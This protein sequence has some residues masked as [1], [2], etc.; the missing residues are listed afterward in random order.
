MTIANPIYDI[1]FKY[2]MEDL[3]IAKGLLSTILNTEIV[4][5]AVQPQEAV[6]ETNH[7]DIAIRIFRIDFAAIIKE[8]DGATRKILIELQ[9]T[10]RSTN[11]GRFRRYLAENY[12]K[13]DTII[14][15]GIETKESLEIVTIYFLGFNLDTVDAPVLYVKNDFIDVINGELVK[16]AAKEDFVRLLTHE[17]YMIQLKKLPPTT[18]TRLER[19]LK[20]FNQVYKLKDDHKL[21]IVDDDNDPLV[22]KMCTRL[23][24]A[25]AD[26]QMRK[27][28][29]IED[30]IDQ[31]FQ[32]IDNKYVEQFRVQAL[33]MR[34]TQAELK[35]T[36]EVLQE[37]DNA[38]QEKD[39]A[40]QEKDNA[41][42]AVQ[43]ALKAQA[44]MIAELKKRLDDKK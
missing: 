31:E 14:R 9:K 34:L 15:N 13:E 8:A 7:N 11:I 32:A 4:S 42:Q 3:D 21:E 29:D 38:L 27:K 28:M 25:I 6:A 35:E 19:V 20:V 36:K 12:A 40:L 16:N 5:I 10:K 18:K 22:Q 1:V 43:E 44:E 41:L 2:L 33:E 17:S 39:N 23:T 24:R 26:E 37:K 30:E